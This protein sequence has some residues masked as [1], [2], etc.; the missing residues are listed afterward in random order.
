M[1]DL[2]RLRGACALVRDRVYGVALVHRSLNLSRALQQTDN[3][4]TRE[5]LITNTYVAGNLEAIFIN[6]MRVFFGHHGG[7]FRRR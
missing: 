2:R 7:L 6:G 1:A 5:R 3:A 4:K